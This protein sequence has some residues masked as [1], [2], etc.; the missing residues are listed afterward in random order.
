MTTK[1]NKR[2]GIPENGLEE[3]AI[4]SRHNVQEMIINR[5]NEIFCATATVSVSRNRA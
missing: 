5:A 1:R 2:C 3:Y 4:V